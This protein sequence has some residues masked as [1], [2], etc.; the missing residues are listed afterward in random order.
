MHDQFNAQQFD[1]QQFDDQQWAMLSGTL[2]LTAAAQR[3]KR[4]ACDSA[5][6]L[7]PD[8]C[9]WLLDRLTP[10]L[11]SPSRK[12]TASLLSKRIAF[13]TTASSLYAMSV[14][15]KGL[16]M[17]LENCV[18]EYG[19]QKQWT[20]TMPLYDLSVSQPTAGQREAWRQRQFETLFGRHLAPLLQVLSRI[21]GAPL[22]I[23][24]ENTA[25][26]IFSLY[27]RRMQ[28]DDPAAVC[29]PGLTVAQR[30]QQDFTA[31]I[32]ASG[33][34]FGTDD[35]PLKPFYRPKTRVP[36][37]S[38]PPDGMC[39]REVRFR[40]TCCFYYKAS[41]PPAYCSTCPLSRPGKDRR[42]AKE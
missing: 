32:N 34:I 36:V 17:S 10:K 8:Y 3:D 23:L 27:E 42:K 28:W 11:L 39:F 30:I 4:E 29:L 15:N 38:P 2:Q 41:Q 5:A 35:N 16:N 22:R 6:L 21:S 25:V 24:W 18:L 12:I 19:H 1:A 33:E 31:L 40:R 26:R 9:R 7:D 37:A 13:L 20:S 14:Y